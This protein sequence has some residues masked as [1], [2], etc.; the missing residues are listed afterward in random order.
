[1]PQYLLTQLFNRSYRLIVGNKDGGNAI[2][3]SDLQCVFSVDKSNETHADTCELNIYNVSKESI[4]NFL[5]E[6]N[7]VELYAGYGDDIQPIFIGQIDVA[8][9]EL[10]GADLVVKLMFSDGRVSMIETTVDKNFPAGTTLDAVLKELST[11]MGFA[12]SSNNGTYPAGTGLT[13]VYPRGIS[14]SGN[15]KQWIDTTIKG[16]DI[17]YFVSNKVAYAVPV[18]APVGSEVANL[19]TSET[20]LIGSPN[21][22][23]V[24]SKVNKKKKSKDVRE[25]VEF[26]TLLAGDVAVGTLVKVESKFVNG[27]YQVTKVKHS[28]DYR[29]GSWFSEIEGILPV[30]A[31]D[32][33]VVFNNRRS[34][35][36]NPD[37]ISAE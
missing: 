17:T 34:S 27:I 29:G 32:T 5:I 3:F 8:S 36:V 2:E 35:N 11:D 16:H 22:K 26:R 7:I 14:V 30:T 9:V 28:G 25:G 12:Y 1:M 6:E 13:Y 37:I 15:V 4:N 33:E 20:G 18:N 23:N 10:N 31:T 24:T 21:K 19:F